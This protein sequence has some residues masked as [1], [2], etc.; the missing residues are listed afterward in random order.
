MVTSL[1]GVAGL[2]A[3]IA[4]G[5]LTVEAI[6]RSEKDELGQAFAR[7]VTDLRRLVGQVQ[8]GHSSF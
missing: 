1:R 6:A 7:M 8:T 3:R 4:G 2:A 5:D